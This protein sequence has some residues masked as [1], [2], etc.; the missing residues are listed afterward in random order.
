MTEYA[1]QVFHYGLPAYL[2][3]E[4]EKLQRRAL[5]IIYPDLSYTEALMKSNLSKLHLRR[6]ELT[7]R[8]FNDVVRDDS[9]KIH[10][11]LPALNSCP[12]TLRNMRKFSIPECKTN[13]FQRSFI[14]FNAATTRYYNF[15]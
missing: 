6:N 11:L 7:E 1:C 2:S 14:M 8:L 9:N 15:L 13:R 4:L 10:P 12:R 3:D 5:R